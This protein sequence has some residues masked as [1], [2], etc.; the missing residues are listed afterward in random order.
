[1]PSH[2]AI[3][4]Q[5]QLAL[6]ELVELGMDFAR[7]LKAKVE[8]LS[9]VEDA[10]RLALAFHRVTRSVRLTLALQSKL[11]RDRLEIARGERDRF[12]VDVHNRVKQ[13]RAVVVREIWTE[14]EGET[15][16]R[17]TAALDGRLK[18]DALFETFLEG[19]VEAAIARIREDLGLAANDAGLAPPDVTPLS[20]WRSSG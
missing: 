2:D 20:S 8:A 10:E 19:P 18:E 6:G 5:Q 13:V 12:R 17:L 9:S 4:D 16:E 14:T 15:A 3:A 11:A 1:M 7:A